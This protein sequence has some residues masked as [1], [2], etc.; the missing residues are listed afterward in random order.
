M[1]LSVTS[2]PYAPSTYTAASGSANV[3]SVEATRSPV[4]VKIDTGK[5]LPD[6]AILFYDFSA[7]ESGSGQSI[8]NVVYR[9]YIISRHFIIGG[10]LFQR[11]CTSC[12]FLSRI[13]FTPV[14]GKSGRHP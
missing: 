9:Y 7:H 13:W 10:F 12:G 3:I 4:A 11:I 1:E 8:V 2:V 5:L 6:H 14:L